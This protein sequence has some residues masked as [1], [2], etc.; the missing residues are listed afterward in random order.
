MT[1]NGGQKSRD[2]IPLSYRIA[3]FDFFFYSKANLVICLLI[4][5]VFVSM[6]PNMLQINK[7][8]AAE[9]VIL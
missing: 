6:L 5:F 7:L 4:C 2:T 1:K 8:T 9:T 3:H